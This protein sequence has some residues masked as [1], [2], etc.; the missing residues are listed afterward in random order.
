MEVS[1]LR[2]I[3]ASHPSRRSDIGLAC[4]T[5]RRDEYT[6]LLPVTG[7][8]NM[9]RPLKVAAAQVGSVDRTAS[10]SDTL[11]RMIKLLDDAIAQNVQLV[12]YPETTL[13][14]FFPRHLIQDQE[15]LD[16]FFEK[17]QDITVNETVKPLFD[18]AKAAKVDLYVGYA[19]R[20]DDGTGY[21]SCIY[22]SGA[23]GQVI[24]KYRKVHLPGTVEPYPDPKA[25]NQLEKRYFRPGDLGFSAFRIPHVLPNALK[26]D[27]SSPE[28]DTTGK[29][30]PIAGMLICNDRR[31]P[32]AWRIYGLQGT[33]LILCGYNTPAYAPD[34]YGQREAALSAEKMEAESYF[35]HKLVMEAN[36]Y[37]N[38]CFS[39]HAAR[40]GVDDGTYRLIGGSG[41]VSPQGHTIAQAKGTRD[42]LIVA[43]IDLEDCRAG[44][45]KVSIPC[46]CLLGLGVLLTQ[47][48]DVQLWRP[49]S[50]RGVRA[51]FF[52][53]GCR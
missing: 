26:R 1:C 12:V 52:A 18:R 44:K 9:H 3:Y 48:A 28:T 5:L 19:E 51:D 24:S 25:T 46:Q 38:S 49:S 17:G 21:N 7:N 4:T 27:G 40:A 53:G 31:W 14:T 6:Y 50:H 47:S 10:R 37:M 30:D 22:Y 32:E 45:E 42:E 36:S 34:L 43:H 35:H 23:L 39:I 41:I 2:R 15:E 8:E 16:A 33:E 11:A 29:G 20:C 13:T